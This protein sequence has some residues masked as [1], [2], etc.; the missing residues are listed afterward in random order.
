MSLSCHDACRQEEELIFNAAYALSVD[1][2][3]NCDDERKRIENAGGVVVWAGT[4]R[5][6]GVLAVSRA[7]GD[8]LLKKYVVATPYTQYE[9]LTSDDEV[10]IL[11]SDGLWDVISNQNAIE[12]IKDCKVSVPSARSVCLTNWTL[13]TLAQL[14]GSLV[15]RDE[16]SMDFHRKLP[17]FCLV[18]LH[19]I[20]G[21]VMAD[22]V[23]Q[24]FGK[25]IVTRE[26][27]VVL[28]GYFCP[29]A[30]RTIRK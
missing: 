7:F 15:A 10:A 11:A 4:W 28:E 5:V 1:H 24:C 2:K 6:G 19:C 23:C 26:V 16:T 12:I 17:M 9:Q 25:A 30:T 21:H 13:V 18:A 14:I 8:R 22:S 27:S 20:C 29:C 3:P